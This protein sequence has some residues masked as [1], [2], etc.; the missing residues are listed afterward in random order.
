MFEIGQVVEVIKSPFFCQGY[1]GEV[2]V[3]A[4]YPQCIKRRVVRV[5]VGE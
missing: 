1:V 4:T 2:V 3:T 5:Y